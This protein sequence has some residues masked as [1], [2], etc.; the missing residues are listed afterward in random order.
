MKSKE[1]LQHLTTMLNSLAEMYNKKQP[2]SFVVTLWW[3]ALKQYNMEAVQHAFSAHITNP[4][5][6][7]FM[8]KPADIIRMIG[9]T[10]Q[11][12]ALVAWSTVDNAI[13]HVG[14]YEDVVFDDPIIHCVVMDMG[15]WIYLGSRNNKE[16]DF[17]KNEFVTRYRAIASKPVE[18]EAPA[19]L[20]G[21]TNRSNAQNGFPKSAPVLIG[22]PDKAQQVY[23][24]GKKDSA[25]LQHNRLELLQ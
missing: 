25:S 20:T 18:P 1:D 4:D 16:W 15:G 5:N 23:L 3:N 22:N 21:I 19:I 9:G 2:T 10:N 6:G 13:R 8:P 12:K 14:T 11:D 7:Q 17:V 24:S